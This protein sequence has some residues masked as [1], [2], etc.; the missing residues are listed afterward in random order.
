MRERRHINVEG[1]VVDNPSSSHSRGVA[2]LQL[3]PR[4]RSPAQITRRK[5]ICSINLEAA[6]DV[7]V[8]ERGEE[9]QARVHQAHDRGGS[10]GRAEGLDTS[11]QPVD[12][13]ISSAFPALLASPG[14]DPT[15]P[16]PF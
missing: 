4:D 8:L 16:I 3:E 10:Q 7:V 15:F 13:K 11:Q 6:D 2:E 12:F 1:V 14:F 5:D 9:V